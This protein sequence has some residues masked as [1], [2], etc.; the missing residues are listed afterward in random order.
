MLKANQSGKYA[1]PLNSRRLHEEGAN[2]DRQRF[3]S[4]FWSLLAI[5]LAVLLIVFFFMSWVTVTPG[6]DSKLPKE[7]K[8]LEMKSTAS[9]LQLVGGNVC[10]SIKGE[11]FHFCRW[12][13][14]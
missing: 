5:P 8:E 13:A 3:M 12:I 7:M 1:Y 4:R 14:A 9:G 6:K 10:T 2:M 11:L